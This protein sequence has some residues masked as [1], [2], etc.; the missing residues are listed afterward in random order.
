MR[1]AFV[2]LVV[3]VHL[4][5]DL[6]SPASGAF[7]FNPYESVDGV[8]AEEVQAEALAR[9]LDSAPRPAL[10]SLPRDVVKTAKASARPRAIPRGL[11]LF[12]RRHAPSSDVLPPPTEDH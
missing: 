3:V 7:R 1:P 8:R 5:C 12:P 10:A 6:A 4:L 11:T 9:A 2:A